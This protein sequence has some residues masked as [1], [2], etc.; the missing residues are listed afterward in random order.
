MTLTAGA[1][2]VAVIAIAA[3]VVALTLVSKWKPAPALTGKTIV[4]QTQRPDDQSIR[5]VCVAHHSDQLTLRD[6]VYLEPTGDR[7]VGGLVHVPVSSISWL[8]EIEA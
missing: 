4:V 1:L 6:A 7:A 2:L 8:Q 3:L 5:G